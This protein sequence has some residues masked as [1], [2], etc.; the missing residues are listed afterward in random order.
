MKSLEEKIK[1]NGFEYKLEGFDPDK[2]K[3]LY[4]Q[5]VKILMVKIP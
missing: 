1:D 5:K 4:S 2:Q 3:D